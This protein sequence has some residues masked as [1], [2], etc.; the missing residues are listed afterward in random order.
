MLNAEGVGI[1]VFFGGGADVAHP[2]T[3]N[4]VVDNNFLD[5]HNRA[6]S[7]GI[8]VQADN[9]G[10]TTDIPTANFAVTNNRVDH[11]DGNGII[12][13][14]IN[15]AGK[16]NIG[17]RGNLVPTAPTA[18]TR[19]GIRIAQNNSNAS[20]ICAD[21]RNNGNTTSPLIGSGF[22]SGIG[23]RKDTTLVFGIEGMAATSTPGVEQYVDS[24]NTAA[25]GPP[26]GDGDG[27][28]LISKTTGFSICTTAP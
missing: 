14:A 16:L 7:S 3:G 6:G 11:V 15:N 23:L 8:G 27:V 20:A 28:Q 17:V 22:A 9:G 5:L 2:F 26:Y 10:A 12:G 1:S 4:A 21:I 25:P 13:I 19:Y 24:L 18:A